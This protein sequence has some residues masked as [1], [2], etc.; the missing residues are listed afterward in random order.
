MSCQLL[1]AFIILQ[2]IHSLVLLANYKHKEE[3][4]YLVISYTF[5]LFINQVIIIKKAF[6]KQIV[7]EYSSF[8][9]IFKLLNI[10]QENISYS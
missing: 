7:K 2:I 4:F 8:V 10:L 6:K 9:L 5:N 3:D 1:L